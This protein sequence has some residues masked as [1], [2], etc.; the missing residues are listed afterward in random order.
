MI[1]MIVMSMMILVWFFQIPHTVSFG[2]AITPLKWADQD[3]DQSSFEKE[4]YEQD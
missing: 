2:P 4:K 3:N 1:M